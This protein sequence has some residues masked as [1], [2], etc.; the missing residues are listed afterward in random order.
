MIQEFFSLMGEDPLDHMAM[1][2]FL[3]DHSLGVF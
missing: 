2:G 1:A 3:V